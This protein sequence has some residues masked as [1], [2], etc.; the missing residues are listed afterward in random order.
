MSYPCPKG[1]DSPN[2]VQCP[3]C[4]TMLVPLPDFGTRRGTDPMPFEAVIDADRDFYD[5][6]GNAVGGDDPIP[7]PPHAP[8]RVV[9]LERQVVYIGRSD[10]GEAG[11]RPPIDLGEVPAADLGVSR[12]VHAILKRYGDDWT[13]HDTGSANGTRVD[14]QKL[15]RNIETPLRPDSVIHIG[16]WTAIRVRERSTGGEAGL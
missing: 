2:P 5:R 12:R 4:G 3:R 10:P 14:G 13:V 6:L 8:R 1:H 9:P 7:F 15:E 16:L 11:P